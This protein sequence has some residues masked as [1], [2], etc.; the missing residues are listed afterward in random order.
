MSIS[1]AMAR[2][3]FLRVVE[4]IDP[5]RFAATTLSNESRRA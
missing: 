4:S 3:F 2:V 5:G 1:E